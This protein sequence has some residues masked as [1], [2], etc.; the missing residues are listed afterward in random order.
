MRPIKLLLVD[1]EEDFVR[2]LAER[3]SLRDLDADVALDGQS[4][5][6]HLAV[7]SEKEAGTPDVMV[8]DL[9]MPGVDGLEVL[10]QA[11]RNYP[12]LKII[13]LTGHGT[14][15]MRKK[16][17]ELGAFAYLRKPVDIEDLVDVI[18]KAY[19]AGPGE[20]LLRDAAPMP[21]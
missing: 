10:R 20:S 14:D 7:V 11:R 2:T 12:D 8:L 3:V 18:H 19:A 5:L 6:N 15:W 21:A 1:D 13:I 9:R 16:V 17:A 4:A